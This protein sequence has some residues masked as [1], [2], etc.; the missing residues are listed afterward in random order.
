MVPK[1]TGVRVITNKTSDG[2]V[3]KGTGVKVITGQV[4]DWFQRAQV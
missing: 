2:L 4:M 3:P 1:G